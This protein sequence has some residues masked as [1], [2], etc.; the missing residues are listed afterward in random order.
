MLIRR[1]NFKS[2]E[3]NLSLYGKLQ[4]CRE[5]TLQKLNVTAALVKSYNSTLEGI[6]DHS[7]NRDKDTA[8]KGSAELLMCERH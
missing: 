4:G 7:V 2:K 5:F 6:M 8:T 3:M 1:S